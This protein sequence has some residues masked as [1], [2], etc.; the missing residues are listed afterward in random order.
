MSSESSEKREGKPKKKGEMRDGRRGQR[1]RERLKI[2]LRNL[3]RDTTSDIGNFCR[4]ITS[5]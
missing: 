4:K 5:S 3:P 1:E 2:H